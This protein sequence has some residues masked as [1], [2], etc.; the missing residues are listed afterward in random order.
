MVLSDIEIRAEI[1][2]ERL[3]FDP[4]IT[5]RSRF[6]S[7][8]V[9]L[10]LHEEIVIMPS[11]RV[12]GVTVVPSDE[13]IDV[14]DIL[15]RH[16]ESRRLLASTDSFRMEPYRFLIGKTLE[17]VRLPAHLA[18]R[19]EGK[20]SLARLGLAVHVTA[21]TVLAGFEGR[22][23]LEMYNVGPFSIEL[24]AGMKIAQLVLEHVGLPA[25]GEYRGRYYQQQ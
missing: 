18:A 23:Y 5:D 11:G 10:L 15:G 1:N 22:L 17:S 21:P 9:D 14:M 24:M 4:P 8:S 3:V 16:G 2:A 19:I 7:S 25:L 20:S 12:P 13:D 6:G